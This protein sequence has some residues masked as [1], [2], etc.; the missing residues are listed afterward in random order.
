MDD[1]DAPLAAP[2]P[3]PGF[4][5]YFPLERPPPPPRTFELGL[6]LGGTV[7]AG[8]YTAGAL[9]ALVELL[10]AWEATDP[11]HRVRLPIV[12]GCSG[13]G[14]TAGILGLYARKAHHPMPD[15]FAA[16]MATAAMPDNP[17]FDVWVNR[18]DGLAFLDPSDLAGGTAAS[19]LNCRRLD[20]I[21]RDM[22]RY[23]ETPNGFGRAYLP[24]PYRMI[25]SVTNV[26]GIPYRFDVPAFT[27]WTGGNYAQH[28]DYARF[29]LPASGIAAD[30]AGAR[31]PDEFWIG[32]NPSGEGFADFGTLMQYALAGGA[33]PMALRPRALTRPAAQYRYRPHVL[34][35]PAGAICEPLVPDW[36]SLPTTGG[37]VGF[38]GIDGGVFDNNPVLLAHRELA[39]MAA[40]LEPG[41]DAARRALL[42]I[43][44]T[45]HQPRAP[46]RVAGGMGGI[47]LAAL[48]AMEAGANYLTADLDMMADP[49][50]FSHFQLVPVRPD[51]KTAGAAAA[52]TT[53][54][55]A[56]GG[57]FCRAFRVHDFMLGRLNMR[58][59][60]RRVLILRA[61]N[62]LFDGWSLAERQRHALDADGAPLPAVTGA[63]PPA[64]YWLPV[65]P[66]SLGPA[67]GGHAGI[68]PWPAG[69]L[70]PETLRPA[71]GQR[72]AALL[73]IA[74]K[75]EIS[76]LLA[77]LWFDAAEGTISARITGD[78]VAAFRAA[79]ERHDLLPRAGGAG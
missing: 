3:P 39:G 40:P 4:A 58:D 48:G 26:E 21:A 53:V 42:L 11:P 52:A 70:D 29:A 5:R 32:R 68:L 62:P 79:L 49:R 61:D 15:D 18:V 65:I 57:F 25:L 1:D 50:I 38:T 59:Y 73:A 9:D 60:L 34:R 27:G 41:P 24:D 12:T 2:A 76:G 54:L 14:I 19:L 23:G 20:E 36:S 71:L 43:D 64:A 45:L 44:P 22:V 33:Y 72:V 77:N 47:G 31:R 67:P 37:Q 46:G 13:G 66:D 30:P 6:V 75:D 16:L 74:Q 69:Q 51:R 78:I 17:L 63:T 7:S 8:A 55:H 10:D 56:F 28:A 35:T